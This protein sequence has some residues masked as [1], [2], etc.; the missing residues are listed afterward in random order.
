MTRKQAT[1]WVWWLLPVL[2]ARALLPA[3]I[4]LDTSH[5]NPVIVMCGESGSATSVEPS[6][7]TNAGL[8]HTTQS[9]HAAHH[10]ICPFAQAFSAVL[11]TDPELSIANSRW[12]SRSVRS[13]SNHLASFGPTRITLTR[14]P[15]ALS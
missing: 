2:V 7:D 9:S 15:P 4:M 14:G 11:P 10:A 6:T 8:T 3:G 5:G 12:L 1:N 13:Y